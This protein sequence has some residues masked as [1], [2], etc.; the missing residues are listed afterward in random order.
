M[1]IFHYFFLATICLKIDVD[2]WRGPPTKAEKNGTSEVRRYYSRDGGDRLEKICLSLSSQ[3]KFRSVFIFTTHFVLLLHFLLRAAD[4]AST[5]RQ[6]WSLR[7]R[8]CMQTNKL[9]PGELQ[10][11]TTRHQHSANWL[12]SRQTE[13]ILEMTYRWV[14]HSCAQRQRTTAFP[15]KRWRVGEQFGNSAKLFSSSA[16]QLS[17]DPLVAFL[18]SY[19]ILHQ[20]KG[21][22]RANI[23]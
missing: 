4:D 22:M 19:P 3:I 11:T 13:V 20:G 2:N 8:T 6:G 16:G 9:N 12:N 21:Q 1:P 10:L 14:N 23:V 15:D 17:P 7:A 18:H 5:R